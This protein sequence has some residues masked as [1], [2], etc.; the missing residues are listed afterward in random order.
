[1]IIDPIIYI[2]RNAPTIAECAITRLL[3]YNTPLAQTVDNA[4]IDATTRCYCNPADLSMAIWS[5]LTTAGRSADALLQY[6][7]VQ[8]SQQVCPR[9]HSAAA[10]VAAEWETSLTLAEIANKI[11]TEGNNHA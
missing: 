6:I 10:Y 9:Y 7:N 5:I 3:W 1:M 11:R 4:T 8:R 2:N